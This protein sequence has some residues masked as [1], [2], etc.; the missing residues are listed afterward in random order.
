[1]RFDQLSSNSTR[2][3]TACAIALGFSI[4]VSVAL[5]NVLLVLILLFVLLRFHPYGRALRAVF[6]NREA[7]ARYSHGERIAAPGA[8]DKGR[9]R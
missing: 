7:A 4:P 1:M 5:D 6:Q 2:A 3:A 8:I 9:T